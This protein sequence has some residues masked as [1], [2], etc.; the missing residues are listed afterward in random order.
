MQ[1][2]VK[3]NIYFPKLLFQEIY[4]PKLSDFAYVTDGACS[5]AEILNQELVMLKVGL[6]LKSTNSI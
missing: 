2:Q 3:L 6:L 4:P 5:D 1:R